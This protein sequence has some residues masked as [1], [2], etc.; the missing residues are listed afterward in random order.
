[1]I[2]VTLYSGSGP[3]D[4][5][6]RS[7]EWIA[8]HQPP[9][10]CLHAWPSPDQAD[11][12]REL[13]KVHA[14]EVW[15]SPGANGLADDPLASLA[16]RA[17]EW[18]K[19]A[20]DNGITHVM[21][22]IERPSKPGLPGWVVDDARAR[23]ALEAPLAALLDGLA[24]EGVRV[25]ITSHDWPGTHPLPNNAYLHPAVSLVAPQVYPATSTDPARFVSRVGAAGRLA[26]TQ[27]R[28]RSHRYVR[29]DLLPGS[30]SWAIYGQLWGHRPE[31]VAW[32]ADQAAC[33]LGWALPLYPHGR[34]QSAGLRGLEI[35]LDL[36]RRYGDSAGA[37]R[38]AQT[39]LGV[40]A[41]GVLGP[42][43]AAALGVSLEV[44]P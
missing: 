31:S 3:G 36:R 20:R 41:D 33:Y 26:A 14:G 4:A 27:S 35:A 11:D 28:W 10:V 12:L 21:P 42:I 38:R 18:G 37:I 39:A 25:A 15:F 29:P 6:K 43:T 24:T 13:R 5:I 40:V 17:R 32:L 30:S 19:W 8:K 16:K 23:A 22:N 9:L 1:M 34:A 2:G 7:R 44:Q